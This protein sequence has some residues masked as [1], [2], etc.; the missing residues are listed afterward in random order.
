MTSP[1]A[2]P[3]AEHVPSN[4]ELVAGAIVLVKAARDFLRQA[5]AK[6]SAD[7]LARAIKSVEGAHR[8]ALRM[9]TEA[10]RAVQ[11]VH[12]QATGIGQNVDV[13]G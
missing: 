11:A 10:R 12:A 7:Y 8:H 4:A 3:D 9:E 5:G 13:R 1:E 2:A 6:N